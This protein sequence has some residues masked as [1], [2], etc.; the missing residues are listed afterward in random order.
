MN[1]FPYYL[2]MSEKNPYKTKLKSPPP[3]LE[4]LQALLIVAFLYWSK[5]NL[6]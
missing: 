2:S 4:K 1:P 5:Y 6:K 3:P